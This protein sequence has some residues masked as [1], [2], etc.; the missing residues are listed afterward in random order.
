MR[1]MVL[2]K[3][4]VFRDRD[5]R[6]C[7]YLIQQ[8]ER[9]SCR[10]YDNVT[11]ASLAAATE[12][13]AVMRVELQGG[14][15]EYAWDGGCGEIY[16]AYVELGGVLLMDTGEEGRM[17]FRKAAA[18]RQRVKPE[19]EKE[20]CVPAAPA[21]QAATEQSAGGQLE[22]GTEAPAA[23]EPDVRHGKG[24]DDGQNRAYPQRRWPP[25][26]LMRAPVYASG[27]WRDD[28][29]GEEG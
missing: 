11:G 1:V 10:L 16:A 14:L 22:C 21:E 24:A 8:E 4:F 25:P 6:L 28:A 29:A 18:D 23:A 19:K 12:D 3:S 20:A 17:L 2:Q 7:G 15:K 13:G 9:I 26:I 5:D 27:R